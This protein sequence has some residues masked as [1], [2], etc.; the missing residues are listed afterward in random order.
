MVSRPRNQILTVIQSFTHGSASITPPTQNP[1]MSIGFEY[2]LWRKVDAG[3]PA[4]FTPRQEG[5]LW[6]FDQRSVRAAFAAA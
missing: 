2:W 3:S 4:S 1:W 6:P 5:G